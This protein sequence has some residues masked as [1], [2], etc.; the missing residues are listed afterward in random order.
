MVAMGLA[1][2][3]GRGSWPSFATTEARRDEA[4][5]LRRQLEQ[6]NTERRALVAELEA[7]ED[8]RGEARAAKLAPN[9]LIE[10]EYS[11]KNDQLAR[12]TYEV[13]ML[14]DRLDSIAERYRYVAAFIVAV[15]GLIVAILGLIVGAY[16]T[17]R[18]QPLQQAIAASAAS[19]APSR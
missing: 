12:C 14:S 19:A 15:L 16:A 4:A 5:D 13:A 18:P 2:A 8:R 6:K 9:S 7:I 17:L 10:N 11:S 1:G 3:T